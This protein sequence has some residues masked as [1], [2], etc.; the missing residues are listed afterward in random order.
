M[1]KPDNENI[2]KTQKVNSVAVT[3]ISGT[4]LFPFIPRLSLKI[5]GGWKCDQHN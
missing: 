4:T 2:N 3:I 1:A 5:L